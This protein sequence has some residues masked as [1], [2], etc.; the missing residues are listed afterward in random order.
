MLGD[1]LIALQTSLQPLD[2]AIF[3][4]RDDGRRAGLEALTDVLE[5]GV[6]EPLVTDFA[7]DPAACPADGGAGDDARWKDQ[8]DKP[9]RDRTAL[10]PLLTA[11]VRG[12][13]ECHLAVGLPYHHG[14]VDELHGSFA[15]HGSEVLEGRTRFLLGRERCDEHLNW[16]AG[17]VCASLS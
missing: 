3:G 15:V 8:T 17:H 9:A 16:V 11:R 12:L 4:D 14:R 7:P 5:V 1:V 2:H 6:L 13:L 10:R